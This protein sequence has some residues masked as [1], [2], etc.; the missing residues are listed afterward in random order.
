VE[1]GRVGGGG[2][3]RGGRGRMHGHVY[4]VKNLTLAEHTTVL[5]DP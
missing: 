2:A 5:H 4:V 1:W 3:G